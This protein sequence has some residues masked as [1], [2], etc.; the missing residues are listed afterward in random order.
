MIT[1]HNNHSEK[2]VRSYLK[3]I[4]LSFDKIS[5]STQ[6]YLLNMT[7][8]DDISAEMIASSI[9]SMKFNN[10]VNSNMSGGGRV[11]LPSEYFGVES[12]N[13]HDIVVTTE[14]DTSLARPGL[15]Y[16]S[17]GAGQTESKPRCGLV[18]YKDYKK[19]HE[20]YEHKFLRR[21]KMSAVQ[22]KAI[23]D[24]MNADIEQAIISAVKQNKYGKL[25]KSLLIKNLKELK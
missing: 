9:L 5:Q 3:K 14:V 23:V 10:M 25:T 15:E 8:T 22:K 6:Q 16:T 24:K 20:V 1:D 11:V 13:Y 19:F 17:T 7:P 18:T 2:K 4:G 12:N 21:L